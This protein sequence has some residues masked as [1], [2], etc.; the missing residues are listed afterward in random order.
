MLNGQ[1]D[2]QCWNAVVPDTLESSNFGKSKKC[3]STAQRIISFFQWVPS[4]N[5]GCSPGDSDNP[6]GL[7]CT[8]WIYP[9]NSGYP[10]GN[11]QY[12]LTTSG[13]WL[14]MGKSR[15]G[16]PP[17]GSGY[18]WGWAYLP[19]FV[20][21]MRVGQMGRVID[22]DDTRVLWMITG[23]V[24]SL[25]WGFTRVLRHNYAHDLQATCISYCQVS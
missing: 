2:N 14:P 25:Y 1:D 18:P 16:W 11:E 8:G 21:V 3:R 7:V 17:V 9:W 23:D 20:L 10:W 15:T 13:F 5:G 22:S 4:C 24:P 19:N 6:W 12:Y